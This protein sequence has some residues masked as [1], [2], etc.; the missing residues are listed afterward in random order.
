[1]FVVTA[2]RTADPPKKMCISGFYL[3]RDRVHSLTFLTHMTQN[4]N[5]KLT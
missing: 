2:H 5:N 3:I 1:M 4:N